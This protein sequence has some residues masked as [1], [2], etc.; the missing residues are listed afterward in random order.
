MAPNQ[1]MFVLPLPLPCLSC[2]NPTHPAN[3]PQSLGLRRK[4]VLPLRTYTYV[5]PSSKHRFRAVASDPPLTAVSTVGHDSSQQQPIVKSSFEVGT[6]ALQ[7]DSTS[8]E[9]AITSL[10]DVY[11]LLELAEECDLKDLR[12]VHNGVKVEITLPGGRG[13]DPNGRLCELPT[14]TSG[15]VVSDG[16]VPVVEYAEEGDD[17]ESE[18]E[19]VTEFAAANGE[20]VDVQ[21]ASPA[22]E[23]TEDEKDP[24]TVYDTDFVVTS[25]RVGFFFCGAKNKPPLVNVGDHV[26][27]NQPVCII[28]QLGQQYVYL[29][30]AS[31]NVVQIFVEDSEAVEYG[32]QIMVIRP[33]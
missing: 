28:E 32:T 19:D 11:E 7:T 8:A 20:P 30:E 33:D 25:D 27:F 9:S 14:Q 29:S 13:F 18:V 22:Q 31:G 21:A 10:D 12:I 4:A 1:A 3:T 2:A 15:P 17:G 23:S 26:S 16:A 6:N 5:R 24:N